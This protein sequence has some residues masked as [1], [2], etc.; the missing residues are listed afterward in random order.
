MRY[1]TA[2]R[3]AS[4]FARAYKCLVERVEKRRRDLNKTQRVLRKTRRN[5][6]TRLIDICRQHAREKRPLLTKL[7]NTESD[8]QMLEARRL[9]VADALA[10][11]GG[12]S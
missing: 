5:F 8:L 11:E 7:R 10:S 9:S 6:S 4:A 2:S 3:E 1:G 12:F